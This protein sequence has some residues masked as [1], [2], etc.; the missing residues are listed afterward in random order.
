MRDD[1]IEAPA[2]AHGDK[3]TQRTGLGIELA[4]LVVSPLALGI[5]LGIRFVIRHLA[6]GGGRRCRA[7]KPNVSFEGSA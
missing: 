2:L 6:R 3:P 1:G 5:S 7:R 4:D